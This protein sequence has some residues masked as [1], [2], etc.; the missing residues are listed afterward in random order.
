[1]ASLEVVATVLA[2][3]RVPRLA[4]P[5]PALPAADPSVGIG[6]VA[7]VPRA[8]SPGIGLLVEI[9]IPIDRDEVPAVEETGG[10]PREVPIPTSEEEGLPD[11]RDVEVA[12]R[13]DAPLSYQHEVSEGVPVPG[14]VAG[15]LPDIPSTARLRRDAAGTSVRETATARLI[16]R[17]SDAPMGIPILFPTSSMDTAGNGDLWLLE[18]PA[19]VPHR[20][21]RAIAM[22]RL[23]EAGA[24]SRGVVVRAGAAWT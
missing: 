15:A 20:V 6:A 8:V 11:V 16:L 5:I 1:M 24:P 9:P 22:G 10:L 21:T 12:R 4:V 18:V 19:A 17:A 23:A 14:H 7:V 13:S 2:P 3:Y